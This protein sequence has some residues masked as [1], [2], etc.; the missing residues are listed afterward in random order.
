M[1]EDPTTGLLK[2]NE[3]EDPRH[4]RRPLSDEEAQKLVEKPTA[5]RVSSSDSRAKTAL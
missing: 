5:V 1:H 4:E 2:L 3:D